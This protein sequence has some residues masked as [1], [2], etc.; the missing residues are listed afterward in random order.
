M[1]HSVAQNGRKV[2]VQIRCNR[3][4]GNHHDEAILMAYLP[5]E[6]LLIEADVYAATRPGA[7][8]P[9]TA[10]PFTVKFYGNIQRLKLDVDRIVPLHGRDVP[11]ADLLKWIGKD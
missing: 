8:P 6:K 4:Q 1:P 10:D 3:I 7:S 2:H 9:A 11:L 5:R